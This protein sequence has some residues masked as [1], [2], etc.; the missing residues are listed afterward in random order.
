MRQSRQN[1]K[2]FGQAR[3]PA[4]TKACRA[5]LCGRPDLRNS[6]LTQSCLEGR[7]LIISDWLKEKL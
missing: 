7:S 4:P 1:C 5:T 6:T 2:I 3:R